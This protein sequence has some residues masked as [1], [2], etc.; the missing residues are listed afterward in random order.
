MPR[1]AEKTGTYL[2]TRVVPLKG[3]DLSLSLSLPLDSSPLTP[4]ISR[5]PL[6]LSLSL[7]LDLSR[8]TPGIHVILGVSNYYLGNLQHVPTLVSSTCRH[9]VRLN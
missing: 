6:S 9:P 7:P 1:Y 8:L 3:I 4:G 5:H 2:W